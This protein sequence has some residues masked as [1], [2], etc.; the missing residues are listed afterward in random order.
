M[1]CIVM[2]NP[3]RVIIC[4]GPW[5]R[6]HV[7]NRYYWM[8]FHSYCGPQFFEDQAM[9]KVYEP[10]DENDPIWAEFGKWFDKYQASKAKVSSPQS[11][12]LAQKPNEQE[13]FGSVYDQI[14]RIEFS[15]RD[16]S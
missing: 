16:D 10:K 13:G 6:L 2:G 4:G 9:E 7:G 3:I 11:S 1:T 8:D 14:E 5:A 12:P 15:T